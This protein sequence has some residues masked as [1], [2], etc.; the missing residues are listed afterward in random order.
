[1]LP[2][3]SLETAFLDEVRLLV[4]AMF[5][6]GF[7]RDKIQTVARREAKWGVCFCRALWL[8]GIATNQCARRLIK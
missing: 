4:E 2:S 7:F 5:G 6:G 8:K 1:M 3:P